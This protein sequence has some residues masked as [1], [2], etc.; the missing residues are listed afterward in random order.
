VHVPASVLS[1]YCIDIRTRNFFRLSD[2]S[3]EPFWA[4]LKARC[5]EHMRKHNISSNMSYGLSALF[6]LIAAMQVGDLLKRDRFPFTEEAQ[7][8]GDPG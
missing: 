7:V 8:R 6:L 4:A 5:G 3:V 1:K 2:G